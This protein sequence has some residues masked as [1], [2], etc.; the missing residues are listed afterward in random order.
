MVLY[1]FAGIG[2]QLRPETESFTPQWG[3]ERSNPKVG[4]RPVVCGTAST[5]KHCPE[6]PSVKRPVAL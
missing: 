4:W 3:E 2:R 6:S 5:L 1:G